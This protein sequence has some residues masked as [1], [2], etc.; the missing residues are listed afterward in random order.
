MNKINAGGK[1]PVSVVAKRE[2]QLRSLDVCR[3]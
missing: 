2:M 1:E 3:W